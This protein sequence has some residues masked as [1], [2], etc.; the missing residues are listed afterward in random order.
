MSPETLAEVLEP[1][2][3]TKPLSPENESV[4]VLTL[5]SWLGAVGALC[6]VD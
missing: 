3:T 2:F 4:F 6:S 1:F 5:T